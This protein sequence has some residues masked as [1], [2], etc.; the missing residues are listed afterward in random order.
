MFSKIVIAALL[1]TAACGGRGPEEHAAYAVLQH[2]NGQYADAIA[3]YEAALADLPDRHDLRLG[4]ARIHRDRRDLE[5]ARE[6]I[7]ELLR[8]APENGAAHSLRIDLFLLE[9]ECDRAAVLDD[10]P[11]KL[12][13]GRYVLAV[14]GR[15]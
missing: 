7:D 15:F 14:G 1:L 3:S 4:L 2:E 12:Q 10:G 5:A 6:Q 8:R 11:R 9:G 13:R